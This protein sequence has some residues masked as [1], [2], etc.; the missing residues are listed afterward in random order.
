M[1]RTGGCR[2]GAIRYTLSAAPVAT[3]LCW[4]R[5]CQYWATGNAAV[6]IIVPRAAVAVEGTPRAWESLAD[7]GHHMRRAFCGDCGT[8]L[9]SEA[10]ENTESMVI[11]VGT[12]DDASAVV[13]DVVIW[14]DS[15]PAWAHIDPAMTAWPRQPA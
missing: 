10:L 14:T 8:Q 6:N 13:P 3:R 12:L 9:F 4:C 11:R 1:H 2:C 5:D 15:A 7:S